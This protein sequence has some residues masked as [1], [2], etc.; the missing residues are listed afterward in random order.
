MKNIC[1]IIP[2]FGT[3]PNY[4][5]LFLKSC[6][7]NPNYNWFLITDDRTEYDYPSNVK[8]LYKSFS[9]TRKYIQTKFDFNINL[10]SAYKLC[11]YKP[12]YGYIFEEYIEGFLFWGYCDLDIILGNLDDFISID[13][14]CNYDKIFSLGHMTL[15]RNSYDLNRVFKKRLNNR[16]IYK[17]AFTTD[18]IYRFDEVGEI[19]NNN[20]DG[21]YCNEHLRVYSIDHSLNINNRK[22]AFSR[23]VFKG[24]EEYPSEK[25]FDI[26]NAFRSITLWNHG[27]IERYYIREGRLITSKHPYIH[28]QSRKML[29]NCKVLNADIIKIIPN[30]FRVFPYESITLLNFYLISSHSRNRKYYLTYVKEKWRD[31]K[32]F[33]YLLLYH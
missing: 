18:N 29:F 31:I 21:I 1:F 16:L 3:L 17:E 11:D 22:I 27:S 12:A 32:S 6:Q 5:P 7:S 26:E 4:F 10:N 28:L 9:D 2:Y 8:V 20:I 25:G 33:F 23:V 14:I 30:E 24:I 13:R 15:Y 19:N